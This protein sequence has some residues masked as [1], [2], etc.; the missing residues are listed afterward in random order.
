MLGV[1][2]S[3]LDFVGNTLMAFFGLSA[4]GSRMLLWAVVTALCMLRVLKSI[5]KL[6]MAALGVYARH[7]AISLLYVLFMISAR[8]HVHVCHTCD[9]LPHAACR[10]M[11]IVVLVGVFGWQALTARAAEPLVWFEPA[12]FG[13][14]FG[15]SL[16]AFEGMGVALSV[17]ES[18]GAA[19][20]KPFYAVVTSSYVIAVFLY[21]AVAAWGYVAWGSGVGSVVLASFPPTAVGRS[22]QLMLAVVLLLT[23]PIQVTPVF[24]VW[25]AAVATYLPAGADRLWPLGRAAIVGV[26]AGA[27]YLIPDME[28][29]VGLTGALAFSSIGFVLP[30]LFFLVLRPP[31]VATSELVLSCVMIMLGLVGGA[32]GVYTEVAKVAS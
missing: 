30:G 1:G 11:Y 13:G 31:P 16:F 17:Y 7:L 28:S 20:A 22:A 4:L 26:T 18:M 3:Y 15:P 21:G 8:M 19:E 29:M 10:Y 6:S 2:A 23:Y 25:E 9:P 27:S 14:W 32:W 5:A 24:Q 12:N